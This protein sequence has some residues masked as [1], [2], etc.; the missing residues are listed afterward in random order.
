MFGR[1]LLLL[2]LLPSALCSGPAQAHTL[3]IARIG[4]DAAE[5]VDPTRG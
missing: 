2:L 1:L 3:S 4:I 5:R